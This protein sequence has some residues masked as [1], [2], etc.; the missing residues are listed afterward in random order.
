MQLEKARKDPK[1][2]QDGVKEE[3]RPDP[4]DSKETA[5]TAESKGIV[6]TIAPKEM[7][8]EKDRKGKAKER[9]SKEHVGTVER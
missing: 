6:P 9:D 2:E 3:E 1:E 5:I 4:R 8:R 7:E